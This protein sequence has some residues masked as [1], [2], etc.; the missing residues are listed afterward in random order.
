VLAVGVAAITVVDLSHAAT[1]TVKP[2]GSGMSPAVVV[3]GTFA[4]GDEGRFRS[5]TTSLPQAMLL[6]RSRVATGLRRR[7]GVRTL[8]DRVVQIPLR[9]VSGLAGI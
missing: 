1:I 2:L 5:M 8:R 9:W 6:S 4:D 7:R 3:S